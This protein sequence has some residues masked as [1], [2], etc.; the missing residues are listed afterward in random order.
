MYWLNLAGGV[1]G[2]AGGFVLFCSY[3]L[4]EPQAL[5]LRLNP[6]HSLLGARGV[7]L[8]NLAFGLFVIALGVWLIVLGAGP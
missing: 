6:L 1:L 7:R 8:F 3:L 2:I 4:A 5:A